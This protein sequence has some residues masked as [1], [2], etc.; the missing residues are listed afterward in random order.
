MNN[1]CLSCNPCHPSLRFYLFLKYLTSPHFLLNFVKINKRVFKIERHYF[2]AVISPSA[3][4]FFL[5]SS[6]EYLYVVAN[7]RRV[8]AISA[9]PTKLLIKETPNLAI[10][11]RFEWPL[12][13]ENTAVIRGHPPAR[14]SR[15]LRASPTSIRLVRA[16]NFRNNSIRE[17]EFGICNDGHMYPLMIINTE[18]H[19]LRERNCYFHTESGLD[20]ISERVLNRKRFK[21]LH[22]MGALMDAVDP[23]WMLS[24]RQ[25]T[26]NSNEMD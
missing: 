22:A 3:R 12:L 10:S 1:L 20:R 21:Y 4:S 7:S 6:L 8:S 25:K 14:G 13:D 18:M 2:V 5:F 17:L 9:G 16:S 26:Q 15:R 23:N 11:S 24:T 19:T